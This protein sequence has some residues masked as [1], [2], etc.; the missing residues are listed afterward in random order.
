VE[1]PPS[2]TVPSP[3]AELYVGALSGTSVDGIDV[4]L[5]RFDPQPH[6]IAS[7]SLAFPPAV[8]AELLALCVPG[9][10]EIDRLGRADVAL[11]RVLAPLGP[12]A[13]RISV[14]AQAARRRTV[15]LL[16]FSR[17]FIL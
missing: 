1:I 16:A 4:A 9:E 8:R 10:N 6:L 5:V 2:S 17:R 12:R 7:H 11:G 14:G 13:A 3:A 15:F